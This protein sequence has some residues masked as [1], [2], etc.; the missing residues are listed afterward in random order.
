MAETVEV[1]KLVVRLI[2]DAKQ[3]EG[4][5]KEG[6][7]SFKKLGDD[8]SKAAKR[9]ESAANATGR[10]LAGVATR[11]AG[12]AAAYVSVNSA[13][14]AFNNA[15]ANVTA[16]DHL[17]QATGASVERLSE[18]RNVA[19]AT[20]VDFETVGRAFEQ[21]GARMTEALASPSSRGSQAI[22][23]LSIEVRDAQGNIRQLDELLPEL[24]NRFSQFA[25]GSNKAALAAALFGEEAGPRM[26][27]LLNRGKEGLEGLRRQ[28]GATYTSEDAERVRQYREVVASLQVIL[29]KVV[30]A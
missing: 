10:A 4:T 5:L 15:I 30:I 13:V 16:L 28:L 12:L 27:A 3:L 19:I 14:S 9:T 1:G 25:N 20:G 6:G 26:L 17:S 29:E 23:A 24:A 21:F 7:D 11:L 22:R 2:A 8:A 18:L